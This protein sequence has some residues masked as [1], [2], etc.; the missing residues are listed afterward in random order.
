MEVLV[1]GFRKYVRVSFLARCKTNMLLKCFALLIRAI[2]SIVS[3]HKLERRSTCFGNSTCILFMS[4]SFSFFRIL[5]FQRSRSRPQFDAW[6]DKNHEAP[7]SPRFL[8]SKLQAQFI[9]FRLLSRCLGKARGIVCVEKENNQR[10]EN[11]YDRYDNVRL[12]CC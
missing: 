7:N 4:M 8:V 11:I 6:M 9:C 10:N 12:Y 1:T 3:E 5:S 2:L